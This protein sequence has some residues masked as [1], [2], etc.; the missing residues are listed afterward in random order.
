M[1]TARKVEV[2][3]IAEKTIPAIRKLLSDCGFPSDLVT[4]IQIR[5]AAR[6]NALR[7]EKDLIK[8]SDESRL[9]LKA[10]K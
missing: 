8:T 5:R 2:E 7:W 3:N 6:A 4:A 9:N 1:M 10:E